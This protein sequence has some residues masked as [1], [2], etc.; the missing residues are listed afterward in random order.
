MKKYRVIVRDYNP[1]YSQP[2]DLYL[3]ALD[4]YYVSPVV[5]LDLD[6][7]YDEALTNFDEEYKKY[8]SNFIYRNFE[9]IHVM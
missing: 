1:W 8:Y 5:W 7:N 6:T 2:S 4:L 9:L 3:Y